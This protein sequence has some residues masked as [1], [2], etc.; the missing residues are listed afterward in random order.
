MSLERFSYILIAPLIGRVAV[1]I[2]SAPILLSTV[3][4]G[5][6][7]D[8]ATRFWNGV[9]EGAFVITNFLFQIV[10]LFLSTFSTF[11]R[12]LVSPGRP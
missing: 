8:L 4:E 2:A 5:T 12:P 7:S 9:P 10:S 6:L 3:E 1:P 11:E